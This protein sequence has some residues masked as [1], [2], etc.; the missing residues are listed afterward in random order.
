MRKGTME[1]LEKKREMSEIDKKIDSGAF[2]TIALIIN[3]R[4][5]VTNLGNVHCFVC[6]YDKK[7]LER[8][9]ITLETMHTLDNIQE[10]LRLAD[11]HANVQEAILKRYDQSPQ[12]AIPYTRCFGNFKSKFFYHEQPQFR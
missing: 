3:D 9:V 6:M 2:A 7:T 11:L 12:I 1:F 4:L 5:F 10:M 8:R